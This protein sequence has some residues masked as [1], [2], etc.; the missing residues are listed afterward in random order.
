[1]EGSRRFWEARRA[2]F[3]EFVTAPSGGAVSGCARCVGG[4]A[5]LVALSPPQEGSESRLP[6]WMLFVEKEEIVKPPTVVQGL[7][8]KAVKRAKVASMGPKGSDGADGDG[9]RVGMLGRPA[10]WAISG[11]GGSQNGRIPEILGPGER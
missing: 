3:G 4:A 5:L 9:E 7:Q 6:S 2:I 11:S 8:L 1:M 10:R